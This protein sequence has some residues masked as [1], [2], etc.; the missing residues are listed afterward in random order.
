[1]NL[2]I[3]LA[4]QLD[5]NGGLTEFTEAARLSPSSAFARY[6][7]GRAL[8][9]LT[10]YDEAKVE[11]EAALQLKPDFSSALFLQALIERQLNHLERSIELFQQTITLEPNNAEAFFLL[12]QNLLSLGKKK[13]A[14]SHW[15][16]CVEIKPE[17]VGALYNLSIILKSIEP[18]TASCYQKRFLAL[19]QK[20][21]T[22]TRVEI[23]RGFAV[24]KIHEG[25]WPQAV[26]WFQAALDLCGDCRT[27]STLRKDLGLIYYRSGRLVEG[28]RQLRLA[29]SLSPNDEETL[30]TLKAIE[31]R[32]KSQPTATAVP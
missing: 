31:T 20:E 3:A 19:K 32:Q 4:E 25:D 24:A 9:N 22:N 1:L 21:Q 6:H 18:L 15:R 17:H 11:T 13:E 7:K 28:E 26:E 12:G 10:Q 23:L 27:E 14:L 8:F 5:L 29:L 2:G 16:H 30:S